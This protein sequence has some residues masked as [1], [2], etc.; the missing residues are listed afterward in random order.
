MDTEHLVQMANRIAEFF[1]AMPDHGEAVEGVAQ[2]IR[3]FWEPRMRA[4]LLQHA[5]QTREAGLHP[6]VAE[7]LR[8]HEALLAP[9]ARA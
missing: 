9:A 2:H 4:A 8:T 7:A 5:R 3:R 6:L 1:D